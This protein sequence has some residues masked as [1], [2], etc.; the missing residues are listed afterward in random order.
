[1]PVIVFRS[2][3]IEHCERFCA[4]TSNPDYIISD[5]TFDSRAGAGWW[6]VLDMGRL[7]IDV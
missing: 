3:F 6:I 5:G 2:L 4:E 7:E 1:M